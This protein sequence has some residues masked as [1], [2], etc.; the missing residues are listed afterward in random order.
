MILHFARENHENNSENKNQTY[1]IP[2]ILNK[3]SDNLTTG[4]HWIAACIT[5][6]PINHTIQYQVNDSYKLSKKEK[7]ETERLIVNAIKYNVTSTIDGV[8]KKYTAFNSYIIKGNITSSED[9]KDSYSC[10]YRALHTAYNYPDVI[11]K[12]DKANSFANCP[13]DGKSLV[14]Y[15]YQNQL[16]T[17]VVEDNYIN[18]VLDEN[19]KQE[20]SPIIGE[21]KKSLRQEMVE[22]FISYIG[23]PK[24]IIENK[25]TNES[26]S[27]PI[28]QRK[29][30]E[31]T[32]FSNHIIFPGPGFS[33]EGLLSSDYEEYLLLLHE[34]L[35]ENEKILGTLIIKPSTLASL[36]GLN[37][38]CGGR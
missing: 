34:K 5:V 32:M 6:D 3:G 38:F 10:G 12:N 18:Q 20:F 24:N 28:I 30:N 35:I 37:A 1:T 14:E 29:L 33:K 26:K 2:I 4:L 19:R 15:V 16:S 17:L 13:N 21:N 11:G 25:I 27:N 22:K 23:L 9:Q 36:D 7:D 8:T 31:Y